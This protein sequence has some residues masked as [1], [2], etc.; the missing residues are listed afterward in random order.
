MIST[1]GFMS[2]DFSSS[3]CRT[4]INDSNH[5]CGS[6]HPFWGTTPESFESCDESEKL[7]SSR[8]AVGGKSFS[9]GDCRALKNAKS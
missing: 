5:I 7:K 4:M 1:V 6:S 2:H 9:A 3:R 8:Q